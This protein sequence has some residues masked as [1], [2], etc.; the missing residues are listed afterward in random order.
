MLMNLLSVCTG[1][2]LSSVLSLWE[3]ICIWSP[4]NFSSWKNKDKWWIQESRFLHV[5]HSPAQMLRLNLTCWQWPASYT[6]LYGYSSFFKV[7]SYTPFRVILTLFL[8]GSSSWKLSPSFLFF[9]IFTFWGLFGSEGAMNS[10]GRHSQ[11]I[12]IG[13]GKIQKQKQKR[14]KP[15]IIPSVTTRCNITHTWL[16]WFPI[17]LL[18]IPL[19]PFKDEKMITWLMRVK[20]K[21]KTHEHFPSYQ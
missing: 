6:L 5:P 20:A 12:K 13:G 10:K 4:Q 19:S 15:R 14:T 17:F 1:S 7:Y 9:M 2:K 21:A 18:C 8:W 16:Y 11:C 3:Q